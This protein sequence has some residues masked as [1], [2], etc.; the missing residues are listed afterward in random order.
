[1]ETLSCHSNVS[2]QATA[3]EKNTGVGE[4]NVMK[5]T[6]VGEANVMKITGVGEVNVKKI[7]AKFQLYPPYG[8]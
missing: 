3:K 8:F 1:M 5:I 7:S 2:T 4:A 6:G